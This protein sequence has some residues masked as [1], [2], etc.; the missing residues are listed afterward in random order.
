[1][2]GEFLLDPYMA[3]ICGD[4][5]QPGMIPFAVTNPIFVDADGDGQF[6][7]AMSASRAAAVH[8]FWVPPQPGPHDC[9]PLAEV[10]PPPPAPTNSR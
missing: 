5:A 7:A 10:A 6:R 3:H 1:M 8:D 2:V 9:N 4:P